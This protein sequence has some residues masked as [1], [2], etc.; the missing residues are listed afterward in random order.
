MVLR[1]DGDIDIYDEWGFF[2]EGLSV[3]NN[4]SERD[5]RKSRMYNTHA[6]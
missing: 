1:I 6:T 4:I 3:Q 2:H 5:A